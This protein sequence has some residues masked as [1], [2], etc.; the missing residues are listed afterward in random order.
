MTIADLVPDTTYLINHPDWR[1]RAI[2]RGIDA[3]P[4]YAPGSLCFDCLGADDKPD[5][6]G[7][8]DIEQVST[9][10]STIAISQLV[11]GATY[12]VRHSDPRWPEDDY[13]GHAIYKGP[14][15][16]EAYVP[17]TLVFI[18][19]PSMGEELHLGI[20]EVSALTQHQGSLVD[21]L[22]ELHRIAVALK[23]YD[24]ADW[25]SAHLNKAP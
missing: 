12:M 6:Q 13:N 14:A 10:K 24:A 25:L 23:L 16:P 3:F 21:Q 11:P 2:Y 19:S 9:I 8:F 1:G 20:D 5:A 7:V 17:G 15:D 18:P 4:G 22:T